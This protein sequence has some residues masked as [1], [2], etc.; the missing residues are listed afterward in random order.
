MGNEILMSR[1][2]TGKYTNDDTE[3]MSNKP[4]FTLS[5]LNNVFSQGVLSNISI[6]SDIQ[7]N[8]NNLRNNEYKIVSIAPQKVDS[9]VSL[10]LKNRVSIKANKQ[11]LLLVS[12]TNDGEV[13]ISEFNQI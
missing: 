3:F 5:E 2:N 7:T 13:L 6:L 4:I 10:S 1:D 12:K 11:K 8:I 9:S